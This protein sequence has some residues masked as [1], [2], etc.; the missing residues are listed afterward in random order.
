[1]TNCTLPCLNCSNADF[2]AVEALHI[3]R[4]VKSNFCRSVK[5]ETKKETVYRG[6]KG[7]INIEGAVQW[8]GKIGHAL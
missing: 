5:E 7:K 1:M 6:K 4:N 2:K 8:K 3:S